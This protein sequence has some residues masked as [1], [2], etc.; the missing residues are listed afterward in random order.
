MS[1]RSEFDY[2]LE[3]LEIATYRYQDAP[4]LSWLGE[5]SRRP[6]PG[7]I[8]RMGRGDTNDPRQRYFIPGFPEKTVAEIEQDYQRW[9]GFQNDHWFYVY[10]AATAKLEDE[11]GNTQEVSARTGAYE[12]NSGREPVLLEWTEML[13]ELWGQLAPYHIPR[14]DFYSE[15]KWYGEDLLASVHE[16][17]GD[18]VEETFKLSTEK[19]AQGYHRRKLRQMLKAKQ[20]EQPEGELFAGQQGNLEGTLAQLHQVVQQLA[21]QLYGQVLEPAIALE[22]TGKLVAELGDQ[23]GDIPA[24]QIAQQ[25]EAYGQTLGMTRK[26]E[27]IFKLSNLPQLTNQNGSWE[28]ADSGMAQVIDPQEL[29][30]EYWQK[31]NDR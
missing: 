4:D 10:A 16:R 6:G 25:V 2:W 21:Y 19:Q 12:S 8:D 26:A 13:L 7:A 29:L 27:E 20:Q 1:K 28:I 22:V 30:K 11:Q 23:V 14:S 15:I 9:E 24:D 3:D 18:D 31:E 17:L 5:Y